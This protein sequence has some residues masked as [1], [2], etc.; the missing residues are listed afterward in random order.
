[1]KRRVPNFG[2]ALPL[3]LCAA[4]C[5]AWVRSYAALDYLWLNRPADKSVAAAAWWDYGRFVV[6]VQPDPR[7]AVIRPG[8]GRIRRV[9]VGTVHPPTADR[10]SWPWFRTEGGDTTRHE[11]AGF[12][13]QVTPGFLWLFTVPCW[14]VVLATAAAPAVRVLRLRR[15]RSGLC[16]SCGYDLRATPARC[17]ECGTTAT[18]SANQ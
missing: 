3:L 12:L 18:A 9:E 11:F 5:A 17:P 16:A 1:M 8:E 13:V 15:R 6:A 2:T 14:A 10:P 7:R 4:T